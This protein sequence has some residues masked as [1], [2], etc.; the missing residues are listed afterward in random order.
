MT[1]LIEIEFGQALRQKS[2]LLNA[3]QQIA[4][5]HQLQQNEHGVSGLD[6]ISHLHD[7]RMLQTFHNGGLV[8]GQGGLLRTIVEVARLFYVLQGEHFA[9]FVVV[10]EEHR[11]ASTAAQLL[12]DVVFGGD[13]RWEFVADAALIFVDECFAGGM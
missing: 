7:T 2:V 13:I 5:I 11:S 3:G 9:C 1:Y 6:N 12:A 10:H 8:D 4:A